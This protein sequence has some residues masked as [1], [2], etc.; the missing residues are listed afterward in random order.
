MRSCFPSFARGW[1]GNRTS[2]FSHI[3]VSPCSSIPDATPKLHTGS[4]AHLPTLFSFSGTRPW[5]TTNTRY[6]LSTLTERP[7]LEKI[8]WNSM[9]FFFGE[10]PSGPSP[11]P[12]R[13]CL[14]GAWQVS[15]G[16]V[17]SRCRGPMPSNTSHTIIRWRLSLSRFP[18]PPTNSHTLHT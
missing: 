15:S 11:L 5:H 12:R 7:V 3:S 10:L 14:S 4:S 2:Q 16:V 9:Q 18:T 1:R 13:I 8:A 6:P 17:T